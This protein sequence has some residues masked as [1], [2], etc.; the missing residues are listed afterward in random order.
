MASGRGSTR[1]AFLNFFKSMFGCGVLSL[2]HAFEQAGL[3]AGVVAYVLIAA[4]CCYT[5]RLVIRCKHMLQPPPPPP[6]PP[7]AMPAL[8]PLCEKQAAAGGG[9]SSSSSNSSSSSS[10]SSSSCGGRV[11]ITY[12]DVA[13]EVLGPAGKLCVDAQLILLELLFNAGFLIVIASTLHTL[14]PDAFGAWGAADAGRSEAAWVALLF[15]PIAAL[16]CTRWLRDLW[17]L[18]AFGLLVYLV[19]V[20]GLTY[21][22]GAAQLGRHARPV[23]DDD[24]SGGGSGGSG[25]SGMII[26]FEWSGVRW[27]TLP[28]FCGTAMYSLEGVLM[29]LP[30]AASMVD[31]RQ[32]EAVMAWG[33]ALVCAFFCAFGAFGYAAGF[34]G[35]DIVLACLP[36]DGATAA[37]RVCLV[38]SL[39]AS[40]PIQIYVIAESLEPLL[41][42][43]GGG[44]GGDG[45]NGRGGGVCC[46]AQRSERQALL[47]HSGGAAGGAT[48]WQS[49]GLRVCI[50]FVTSLV[51]VAVPDFAVF[52]DV[53]GNLF[54]PIIG[55]MFPSLLFL[56]IRR[57]GKAAAAAAAAGGGGGG[58]GGGSGGAAGHPPGRRL[59]WREAAGDA[60]GMW[61]IAVALMGLF[62]IVVGMRS[63]VEEIA[64][65]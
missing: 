34:G 37:V 24:H 5:M 14:L 12:G 62:A 29:A 11:L 8:L 4:V 57:S 19:G 23:L 44:G 43:G 49:R 36:D 32:A 1:T 26:P 35:C 38:L 10:S 7:L 2:P 39:I 42:G 60:A 45:G 25:G 56:L 17:P 58:G 6:P 27:S 28:L 13:F 21:W 3:Y 54:Q 46:G 20:M 59:T 18:S 61:S 63:T 9:S 48:K 55:F 64:D 51:A 31:E 50:C 30:T 15:A 33:M 53:V 52:T 65:G 47:G 41:F 16:S 40:S 22:R